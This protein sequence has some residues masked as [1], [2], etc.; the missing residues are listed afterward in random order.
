MAVRSLSC[1]IDGVLKSAEFISL[2]NGGYREVFW[3]GRGC[4]IGRTTFPCFSPSVLRYVMSVLL[5]KQILASRTCAVRVATAS[6]S[7]N[8][9]CVRGWVEDGQVRVF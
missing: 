3:L 7:E 6:C 1:Q 2:V 4:V 8:K 5:D 9:T